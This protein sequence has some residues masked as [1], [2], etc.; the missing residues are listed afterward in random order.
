MPCFGSF[1]AFTLYTIE[2]TPSLKVCFCTVLA[3]K[4]SADSEKPNPTKVTQEIVNQGLK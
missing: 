3:V 1:L 2:I 4:K